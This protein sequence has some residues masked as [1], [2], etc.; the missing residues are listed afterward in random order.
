MGKNGIGM[1]GRQLFTVIGGPGLKNNRS[2]L[3]RTGNI[4]RAGNLEKITA[5]V[6]GMQLIFIEELSGSFITDEGILLPGIP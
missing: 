4:E 3:R 6:E 2:P 1:A 5:M